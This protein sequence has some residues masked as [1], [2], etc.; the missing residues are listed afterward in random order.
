MKQLHILVI[1]TVILG[2]WNLDASA[3]NVNFPDANLAA[4]VR[5]A[6]DLA[7]G[8]DIHKQVWQDSRLCR[9]SELK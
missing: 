5:S 6:L 3:Q 4:A 8:A 7:E 1:F 9:L 2:S